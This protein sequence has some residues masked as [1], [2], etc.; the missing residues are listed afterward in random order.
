MA[1]TLTYS[2]MALG[3]TLN[4]LLFEHFDLNIGFYTKDT[5]VVN[6]PDL[7]APVQIEF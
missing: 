7:E 4:K 1:F 3:L 5:H 6:A 2:I